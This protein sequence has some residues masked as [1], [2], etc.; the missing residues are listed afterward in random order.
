MK[1]IN[2]NSSL[3]LYLQLANEIKNKISMNNIRPGDKIDSEEVLCR[4]YGISRV[5]VR[6]ALQ[7]LC[8]EDILLKKQGKGTFVLAPSL[9]EDVRLSESFSG[10]CQLNN[11]IA[12]TKVVSNKRVTASL[13]IATALGVIAGQP[14]IEVKRI[15][16]INDTPAIYEIDYFRASDDYILNIDFSSTS[17]LAEVINN[18]S[19]DVHAFSDDVSCQ[20]A[21]SDICEKMQVED[22]YHFLVVNEKV[23]SCM[24]QIVY[25]NKQFINSQVYTY[26]LKTFRGVK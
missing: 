5:T 24:N 10:Y 9:I 15:R 3:P 12:I 17:L 21:S 19:L 25:F 23:L 18:S 26:K 4:K 2:H 1:K 14:I 11:Y 20:Q 7:H 6:K 16:Y 8:D 13:D 22:N